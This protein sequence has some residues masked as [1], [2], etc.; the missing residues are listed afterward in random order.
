M[1]EDGGIGSYPFKARDPLRDCVVLDRS[2]GFV[3]GP[4][5]DE[6]VVALTWI[7]SEIPGASTNFLQLPG[8]DILGG[9]AS[10]I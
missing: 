3:C 10:Y 9:S 1:S 5:S 6:L 8:T 7:G 4:R 2:L